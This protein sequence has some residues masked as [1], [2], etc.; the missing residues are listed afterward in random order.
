[1]TFIEPF[2][3]A[4]RTDALQIQ[5]LVSATFSYNVTLSGHALCFT[6]LKMIG[7]L[8]CT[9]CAMGVLFDQKRCPM[10]IMH[11]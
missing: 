5:H 3:E 8:Y 1:M 9:P 11:A 4:L 7:W 2:L 6:S 10:P